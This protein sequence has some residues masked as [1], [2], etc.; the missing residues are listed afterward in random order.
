MSTGSLSDLFNIYRIGPLVYSPD[1]RLLA[2]ATDGARDGT[3][4]LLGTA[5]ALGGAPPMLQDLGQSHATS[6]GFV[7]P[8][9]PV[10]GVEPAAGSPVQPVPPTPAGQEGVPNPFAPT[11][12]AVRR[13]AILAGA[14][15]TRE[16]TCLAFAPDGQTLVAGEWNH[17]NTTHDLVIWSIP[18]GQIKARL[19]GQTSA[20]RGVAYSPD[21][22]WLAAVSGDRTGPAHD[23]EAR[24][25]EARTN[26]ERARLVG[27][28]GP[29]W[30]LVFTP[31][32]R[33]LITSGAEGMVRFWDMPAR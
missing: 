12:N 21:G 1:G 9:V 3:I 30:A 16:I 17:G 6:L 29:I 2:T 13:A 18:N 25:W 11:V 27:H 19:S 5:T 7:P 22:R 4:R 10:G 24:I 8:P 33:T 23:G 26:Q 15:A 28:R 31:D 32:S 14:P 20:I